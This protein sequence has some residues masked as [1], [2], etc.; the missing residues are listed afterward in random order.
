M[1]KCYYF[2]SPKFPSGKIRDKN[3]QD[4]HIELQNEVG[5]PV[6]G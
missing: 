1:K 6:D 4:E 3:E 2:C 5:E